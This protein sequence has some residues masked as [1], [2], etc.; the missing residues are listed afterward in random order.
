MAATMNENIMTER[1]LATNLANIY[2]LTFGIHNLTRDCGYSKDFSN[3]IF[4]EFFDDCTDRD[5]LFIA[6]MTYVGTCA[7]G[8]NIR[9]F[10]L[11]VYRTMHE[12][13]REENGLEENIAYCLQTI[14]LSEYMVRNLTAANRNYY[15]L[16]EKKHKNYSR[17]AMTPEDLSDMVFE[18]NTCVVCRY[19]NIT[20][21]EL[22]GFFHSTSFGLNQPVCHEC[23]ISDEL[24]GE[25][26][27]KELKNDPEYVPSSDEEEEED[28]EE[29]D[30]EPSAS[31][32]YTD[33][34][35]WWEVGWNAG[36]NAGWND[37]IKHASE[38]PISKV[39]TTCDSCKEHCITKKC[40]GT[41]D[42]TVKY[43]SV[44]CQSAH[45]HSIH[46][47]NCTKK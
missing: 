37:A 7:T 24:K 46:K 30:I 8:E 1:E 42:G 16:T 34:S 13:D 18:K 45:W 9:E 36:W 12:I 31:Q 47:Y 5:N 40:S 20:S 14:A 39:P 29:L 43:C 10:L 32:Q 44:S 19:G 33:G 2:H 26:E 3:T 27:D 38:R 25:N 6:I 15:L 35:T 28:G 23:A 4:D 22:M 41:C 21:H 17:N 11:L